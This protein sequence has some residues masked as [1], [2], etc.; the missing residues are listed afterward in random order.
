[1]K[2][3]VGLGNPGKKYEKTR[4]NTGFLVLDELAKD[5]GVSISINKFKALIC[6]CNYKNEN[7]L[8]M[9]P[10]TYMNLS[11]EAVIE[12]MNF[13]RLTPSDIIIIYDDLDLPIGKIRLRQQGSAGGQNGVKN[14]ILHLHTQEFDRIRVGIGKDS[15]IPTADYVLGK[16]KEDDLLEY[17]KS[18][19]YAKDAILCAVEEGFSKAMTKFNRK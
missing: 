10:Q 4:H 7:I 3:I 12:A 18:I 17:E 5:L 6:K 13:Y 14:I 11:G 8:L 1:M 19:K 9:K 2:L 16:T 15:H